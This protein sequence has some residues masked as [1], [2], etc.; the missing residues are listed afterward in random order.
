MII[1]S[2]YCHCQTRILDIWLTIF[3]NQREQRNTCIEITAL[4][5]LG[6]TRNI[7]FS[8]EKIRDNKSCRYKTVFSE[9]KSSL[10]A[11]LNI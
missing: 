1:N 9:D 5:F 7:T 4:E 6:P 11:S 2:C 10:F 3:L 8:D